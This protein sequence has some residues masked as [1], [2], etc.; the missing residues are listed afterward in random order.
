M[1]FITGVC[2]FFAAAITIAIVFF[3]FKYHRKEST[4]VGIVTHE[5]SRLEAVWM[6]VP[7]ILAMAMFGSGAVVYVDYRNTPHETL[8][9]YVVGNQWMCKAQQPNGLDEI[10]ELHVPV[11]RN[12][13]VV[14]ASEEVIHDFFVPA[15]GGQSGVVPGHCS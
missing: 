7:L 14:L 3:F 15:L 4:A 2:V 1:I 8:D 12:I 9:V 10:N 6:I 5:D 11:G 13:R